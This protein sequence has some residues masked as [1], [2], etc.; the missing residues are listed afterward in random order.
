[1]LLSENWP[2][3]AELMADA[4][5]MACFYV[6]VRGSGTGRVRGSAFGE[7]P[8]VHYDLSAEDVWNLSRGL[9]RLSMLLLRAGATDVYPA[10]YG[11]APIRTD[12]EAVRWLDERL[13]ANALALTTVHAFS[14]CPIGERDDRCA[15]DSFGRV[16]RMDNLYIND[17]SML[18]DS[19]GVNPQGTIMALARRNAQRFLA[20]HP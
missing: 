17:A 7:A 8:S 6:A 2:T 4:A 14:S 19:P 3:M 15:A 10:L 20:E 18:P 13:P 12:L 1:M 16:R 9:S 11:V 5:N